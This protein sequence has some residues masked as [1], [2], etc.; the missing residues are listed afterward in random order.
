V[1]RL[2]RTGKEVEGRYT[3]TW[4][5]V[6]EDALDQWESGPRAVVG[7]PAAKVDG[8]ERARGEARYTAD[9]RLPG[10]LH[11][12]LL[13]SP[14]AK[15]RVRSI[16]VEATRSVPGVRSVLAPGEVEWLTDQ[17]EYEG[18]PIA[19]VAADTYGAATAGVAAMAVDWEVLEPLLDPEEA[20]RRGE[21]LSE[22]R[23]HDRG[24]VDRGLAQADVVVEATYR[25]QSV[26]H[27][28]METHQAICDWQGDELTVYISTQF[29]WGVRD[30][31]A[32]KLGDR[33]AALMANHGLVAVGK[34]VDD[35]LHTAMTVEHN[36]TIMWG[37]AQLG[38]VVDLP[39][40]ARTDFTNIYDFVRHHMWTA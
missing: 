28:A 34:S 16:D 2:I 4:I 39:E 31:V 27:N 19:A 36:A 3:E 32:S 40:Q 15:A 11:A 5:V 22:P 1:A 17:A 37:A 38:G 30:E 23:T 8:Y 9:V 24:D 26:L 14:H 6:E 18:Q 25:T 13:R 33:S 7:R 21:L 20:V 29:I 12:A 35:A 10:M